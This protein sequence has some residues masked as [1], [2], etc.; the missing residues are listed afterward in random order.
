M[1]TNIVFQLWN[2]LKIR[3]SGTASRPN[4]IEAA[5]IPGG[6]CNLEWYMKKS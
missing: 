5:N 1:F 3:C 2:S 6:E 4:V